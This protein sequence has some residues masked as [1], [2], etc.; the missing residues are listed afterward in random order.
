L[1]GGWNSSTA[2]SL[3]ANAASSAGSTPTTPINGD[4]AYYTGGAFVRSGGSWTT[5]SAFIDGSL[6]VTGTLAADKIT[7]GS[8]ISAG[9]SINSSGYIKA[10]GTSST[11]VPALGASTWV[12]SFSSVSADYG[13]Y[14]NGVYGGIYGYGNGGFG[15]RGNAGGASSVGVIGVGSAYGVSGLGGTYGALCAGTDTDLHLNTSPVTTATS[16]ATYIATKPGSTSG[17]NSWYKIK[18]GGSPLTY[19]I[20]VWIE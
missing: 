20:P 2:D 18:L 13:L 5:A 7:A 4:V 8:T 3:I 1:G 19:Y 14:A 10:T 15:V 12:G 16:T 17:N 9:V 6:V 11:T